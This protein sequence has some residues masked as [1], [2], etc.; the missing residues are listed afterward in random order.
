MTNF[1]EGVSMG[2]GPSTVRTS[3]SDRQSPKNFRVTSSLS[4]V[5]S[6]LSVMNREINDDRYMHTFRGQL[7]MDGLGIRS[8]EW[9]PCGPKVCTLREVFRGLS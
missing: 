1:V 8:A 7:N 2:K 3:S 4:F 6:S 9:G 5:G